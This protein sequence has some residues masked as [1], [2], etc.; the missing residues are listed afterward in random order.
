[1]FTLKMIIEEFFPHFNIDDVEE[2]EDMIGMIIKKENKSIFLV[3]YEN[4]LKIAHSNGFER[5]C[6][7][8]NNP[9][10]ITEIQEFASTL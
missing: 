6:F 4:K 10:S 2:D 3:I 5:G 8:L 1:M 9:N 7:D